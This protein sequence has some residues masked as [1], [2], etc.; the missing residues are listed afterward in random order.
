MKFRVGLTTR[1]TIQNYAFDNYG[2]I[3]NEISQI[4]D[5]DPTKDIEKQI[6]KILKG[7]SPE[8]DH[9]YKVVVKP[10]PKKKFDYFVKLERK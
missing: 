4:S 7:Y 5:S 10:S 3:L 1:R 9:D 2:R 6:T 8:L